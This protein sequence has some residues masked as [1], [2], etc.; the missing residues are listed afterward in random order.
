M[1]ALVGGLAI[2][3]VAG[4][5]ARSGQRTALAVGIAGE[6]SQLGLRSARSP[7]DADLSRI[8]IVNDSIQQRE[9]RVYVQADKRIV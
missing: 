6:R 7:S 4:L 9:Y 2:T 3:Q 1:Q 8:I 5:F